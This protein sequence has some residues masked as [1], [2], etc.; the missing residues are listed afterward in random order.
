MSDELVFEFGD[1]V[2][3]VFRV[4]HEDFGVVFIYRAG[5][6]DGGLGAIDGEEVFQVID[7]EYRAGAIGITRGGSDIV[8]ID[9][10]F[11]AFTDSGA[12]IRTSP[13]ADVLII[14]ADN[15]LAVIFDAVVLGDAADW[16]EGGDYGVGINI[17][18]NGSATIY[19]GNAVIWIADEGVIY[20]EGI[21]GCISTAQG[22]IR[23]EEYGLAEAEGEV[24]VVKGAAILAND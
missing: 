14:K 19:C 4:N 16:I 1:Y 22:L 12:V 3:S 15:V 7:I 13:K 2:V 21:L 9:G 18:A 17:G 5:A 8:E 11:R 24:K 23:S 6:E 10:Y 20:G